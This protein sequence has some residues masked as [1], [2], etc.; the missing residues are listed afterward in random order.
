MET[1]LIYLLKSA[2]LLSIFYLAYVVLLKQETGFQ[3]N[4]RFLLGGILASAVLPAIYFT[5]KVAVETLHFSSNDLPISSSGTANGITSNFG[6]WEVL[7]SI[8]FLIAFY[9][10]IRL[11]SQLYNIYK[12]IR[13]NKI[14][15]SKRLKFIKTETAVSPFS[16]FQFIVYNPKA[17]CQQDLKMILQHEKIHAAQWHSV[18]ILMANLTTA[19]L[20]FH[21]LSW[22]YKRS[23]AQNLEYIADRETVAISGAKRSYQQ[24]LLKVSIANLQPA[25]TNPFYQ[26]FIKKRILMLNKKTSPKGGLWKKSLVFPFVLA[27]MLAFN[28]K[29]EAQA[30]RSAGTTEGHAYDESVSAVISKFSKQE[31]L[32]KI[33]DI[34]K[35]FDVQLEFSEL[36]Y[37]HAGLTKIK[38]SFLNKVT[39]QTRGFST[40]NSEGIESFEIFKN[41]KETGIR[42]ANGKKKIKLAQ[43]SKKNKIPGNQLYIL[44]GEVTKKELVDFLNPNLIESIRVF[45][46]DTA[47]SLYGKAAKEGAVVITTKV[48]DKSKKEST[49]LKANT[50]QVLS[51]KKKN[52]YKIM[53]IN[54]F[55]YPDEQVNAFQK[56]EEKPASQKINAY[57]AKA[58]IFT[59]GALPAA[60]LVIIDGQRKPS[61]YLKKELQPEDIEKINVL[62]GKMAIE[63]YGKEAKEGVIEITTKKESKE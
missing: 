63:K 15:R 34:F 13:K 28:V 41:R 48:V 18:D 33:S 42:K 50:S 22:L 6:I 47:T 24:A 37:S 61:E 56:F 62:K 55:G 38:V 30:S 32:E 53:T 43:V 52:D 46:G 39:K 12:L 57:K 51:F 4:R 11:A 31:S 44:N 14:H 36:Q 16:F 17:H 29:T 1:F 58:T 25:I 59:N 5:K 3:G 40:A 45:K 7:G 8:Y 19:L 26:S 60:P 54:S 10:I 21:P 9:F 27:F 20:W 49:R 35:K 2:G 23:L